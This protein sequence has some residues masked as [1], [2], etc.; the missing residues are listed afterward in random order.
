MSQ[1][2]N[3]SKVVVV[4]VVVVVVVAVIVVV[5]VTIVVVIIVAGSA[6]CAGN[7]SVAVCF[8]VSSVGQFVI[9]GSSDYIFV[10]V[11]IG[12]VVVIAVVAV[13]VVVTIIVAVAIVVAGSATCAGTGSVA[14]CFIARRGGISGKREREKLLRRFEEKKW[15]SL[16]ESSR[17]QRH[18]RHSSQST[19]SGDYC[20]VGAL[21]EGIIKAVRS[22]VKAGE[23]SRAANLLTSSGIDPSSEDTFEK[24]ALK[25]PARR[26]PV[27]SSDYTTSE[28]PLQIDLPALFNALHR[29][30]K[31]SACSIDGW[32]FEHLE[33]LSGG[34]ESS[35]LLVD[36]CNAFLA[37]EIPSTVATVLAGAKLIA[38]R[39]ANNDVR[40]IAVGNCLRRLTAKAAC[41]LLES[42]IESFLSPYQFGVCTPGGA[43]LMIHVIQLVLQ[44]NP[45]WVLLKTDAKNAFNS[46][47]RKTI[48]DNVRDSF[49]ELLSFVSKCYVQSSTLLTTVG[50]TLSAISSEEG[51][52]Q[53]DPL[54][55]F[56]FALAIHPILQNANV[57]SNCHTVCYLDD[58]IILGEKSQVLATY[59]EIKRRL[60]DIGLQLPEE[61][62]EA[63]SFCDIEDWPIPVP[64][65]RGV[66]VLGSPIGSEEF[67]ESSCLQKAKK[68]SALLEKL[69]LLGDGQT[70]NALLRSCANSKI[71]HLC[72]TVSPH[73]I[74]KAAS[75]HDS[76]FVQSFENI[77]GR[78][79]N[80]AQ[81][82]QIFLSIKHGGFGFQ[83]TADPD[84]AEFFREFCPPPVGPSSNRVILDQIE[85]SLTSLQASASQSSLDVSTFADALGQPVKLQQKLRKNQRNSLYRKYLESLS[86][87][88]RARLL[89]CGG[90]SSGCWLH[91]LPRSHNLTLKSA[92]FSFASLLR[93][94]AGMP[95]LDGLK[96]CVPQCG[97]AIDPE[98]FHALTC[99]W[100]G[101][102]M[103]RHD[104]YLHRFYMMLTS[105]NFRCGKEVLEQFHDKKRLDIVV[106]DFAEGKKLLLDITIT[107]PHSKN[108]ISPASLISGHAASEKEKSKKRKFLKEATVAG[109]LFRPI[110]LE[111]FGQWGSAIRNTVNEVSRLAPREL[112]TSVSQFRVDWKQRL[113]VSL[114]RENCKIVADKV[115]AIHASQDRCL[116]SRG[117][118]PA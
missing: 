27:T 53:G 28:Q 64:I 18:N 45:H 84:R 96:H 78:R 117:F 111:T 115:A 13:A 80:D 8:I 56:L 22:K 91:A 98:G 81:K 83:R 118:C 33:V 108:F 47:S 7:G 97:K 48:L 112:R 66:D 32:R 58:A 114:Q 76:N 113:A 43:D 30:P 41:S 71:N 105:L 38:L 12:D 4:I 73:L 110:A 90:S 95:A 44:S 63:F 68:A 26:V 77:I 88:D 51:V 87:K 75:L 34:D 24:L 21:D 69:P 17:S 65:R 79:L 62:C 61:K 14:V 104:G 106:Y 40:P 39:K 50:D 92:E 3:D 67:V 60:A 99:K 16:F 35:T 36:A 93:L 9:G 20:E 59:Q 101:G 72:R 103:H 94:G 1:Q 74:V 10:D 100:G 102:G 70:A 37:G 29:C 54:G 57:G 42:K 116:R 85:S 5:A 82:E 86:Q 107:H 11:I 2:Q 55:P 31:G 52:Q 46:V 109:H 49:S 6:I 89:S 19:L 23:L 25:H 15:H